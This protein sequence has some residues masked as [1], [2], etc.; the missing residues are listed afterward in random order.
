MFQ[1]THPH[2]VRLSPSLVRIDV[3]KFQSTHPHGVRPTTRFC[4]FIASWF[5][6]THPHG[7]RHHY[8]YRKTSCGKGFNPRT[9]T[10]CDHGRIPQL[11][12]VHCFNPRTH[13]GCDPDTLPDDAPQF[14]K[15]FNP[16]THT[17]CDSVQSYIL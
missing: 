7:V 14:L 3:K 2:G 8:G 17:G 13:T 11:M 15:G 9:H 10:G 12:V 1:S 5:Q 16:R 6:S 4:I